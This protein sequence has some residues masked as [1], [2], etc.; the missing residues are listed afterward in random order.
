[1]IIHYN[2]NAE[3]QFFQLRRNRSPLGDGILYMPQNVQG[4]RQALE[5]V[6]TAILE[7]WLGQDILHSTDLVKSIYTEIERFDSDKG[8][9]EELRKRLES[10]IFRKIHEKTD[11][12]MR[13]L[14]NN[15]T[16]IRIYLEDI[17]DIADELIYPVLLNVPQTTEQYHRILMFAM[18]HDSLSA[19]HIL[20][21]HFERFQTKE[22]LKT[23]SR[24]I[25][26]GYRSCRW[27]SWLK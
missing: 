9:I 16:K 22:D 23:V 1:M 26:E 14:L 11:G 18:T 21:D 8:D 3:K 25:R 19:L 27:K 6:F 15:G 12:N 2:K 7:P 13:I 10:L 5:S 17:S 24:T 20:Y 4:G